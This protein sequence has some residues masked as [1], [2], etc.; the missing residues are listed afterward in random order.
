MVPV[1]RCVF[2]VGLRR[3]CV[4]GAA[5]C[6]V[7]YECG[8]N[9]GQ[10]NGF[11]GCGVWFS[12]PGDSFCD[13]VERVI[14]G[15]D[16]VRVDVFAG[17]LG[18]RSARRLLEVTGGRLRVILNYGNVVLR[19]SGGYSLESVCRE[20]GERV[21]YAKSHIK[22]AIFYRG[23][24]VDSAFLTSAD[25]SRNKSWEQFE[26]VDGSALGGL[27]DWLFIESPGEYRETGS[28]SDLYAVRSRL[29]VTAGRFERFG[30]RVCGERGA[31]PFVSAVADTMRAARVWLSDFSLSLDSAGTLAGLVD[32]GRVAGLDLCLPP[33]FGRRKGSAAAYAFLMNRLVGRPGV[34]VHW[35]RT[36]CK[37]ALIDGDAGCALISGTAGVTGDKELNAC[38]VRLG[39]SPEFDRV[40]RFF[41][42]LVNGESVLPPPPPPTE[43]D[44]DRFH[45]EA[46]SD[47]DRFQ[48]GLDEPPVIKI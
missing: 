43:A 12:P 22:G 42:E 14:D 5:G 19:A 7:W 33:R 36:H 10:T 6:V 30:L 4:F 16:D 40:Q 13:E 35:V 24:R 47:R 37:F 46:E 8:M 3:G 38:V 9:G 34:N 27:F 31:L 25:V 17:A 44:R 41:L 15:R 18:R 2:N 26:R 23:D 1:L 29:L 45:S 28:Q 21:R 48:I 20:L 39:A 32:S 11:A